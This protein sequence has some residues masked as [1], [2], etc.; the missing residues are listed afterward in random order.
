MIFAS[1]YPVDSAEF[2]DLRNAVDKLL[3]NDAS[4]TMTPESSGALGMGLRCGFLGVLHM[5]VFQQ[6]LNDEFDSQVITTAPMVPYKVIMKDGTEIQVETPSQLPP[7]ADVRAYL[8]PTVI[9]RIVTPST[10]VG[11]LFQVMHNRRGEQLDVTY[12]ND[13]LVLMNFRLPWQEVVVDLYD[14]IKSTTAGFAS[15]DYTVDEPREADIVRV[16]ILVNSKPQDALAYVCHRDAAE[17]SGRRVCEKLKEVVKR[18][19][20][21]VTFQAAMNNKI[22]AKTRIAPYRK[23]VLTKS[24]KT[25]GGGDVTRK[26]KLL[27]QQ[28]EGKKAMK[29]LGNVPMPQEAFQAVLSRGN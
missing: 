6:R 29:T 22:F 18:Q 21:E 7:K 4:V 27:E 23:D 13:D 11:H 19:L 25:V 12:M 8:E 5:E 26:M 17:E 24:G 20:F 14:T 15:F 2:S 9:A 16:D 1:I 3:L 28:K 10:Y